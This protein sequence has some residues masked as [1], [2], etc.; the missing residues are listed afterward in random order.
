MKYDELYVMCDCH[1]HGLYVIHSEEDDEFYI[2]IYELSLTG[3]KLSFRER[4]RWVWQII[5]KGHPWTDFIII[6]SDKAKE[7]SKFLSK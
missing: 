4:L 3:R 6:P 1:S 2:N 7:L 5:W